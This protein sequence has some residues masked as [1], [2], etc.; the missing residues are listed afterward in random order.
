MNVSR[1]SYTCTSS[2]FN[3]FNYLLTNK[4]IIILKILS[5]FDFTF[6]FTF[7]FSFK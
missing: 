3:R 2:L 7:N 6:L 4:I 1:T 5:L